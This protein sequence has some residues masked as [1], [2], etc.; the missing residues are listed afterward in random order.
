MAVSRCE[1]GRGRDKVNL[2]MKSR[3]PEKRDEPNAPTPPVIKGIERSAPIVGD[4]WK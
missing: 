1:E 4:E 3:Q 2:P